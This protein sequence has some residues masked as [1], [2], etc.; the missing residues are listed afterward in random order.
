MST[1]LFA[2]AAAPAPYAWLTVKQ[3][4]AR[5]QCGPK[6]IYAA[7]QRGQLRA[8]RLGTRNDLRILES[9]LDA[10]MISLSTPRVVNADA[11]GDD[12]PAGSALPFPRRKDG[13]R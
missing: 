6:L 5:A 4:A 1:K 12:P 13:T 3:A 2:D 7:I 9:W 11:P 10:W 8:S